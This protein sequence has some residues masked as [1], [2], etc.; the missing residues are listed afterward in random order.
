MM[1]SMFGCVGMVL[2]VKGMFVLA[3]C[4]GGSAMWFDNTCIVWWVTPKKCM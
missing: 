1:G 4:Y 3:V 2:D